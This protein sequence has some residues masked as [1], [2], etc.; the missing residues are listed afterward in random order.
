M[1]GVIGNTET[2]L[3][4]IRKVNLLWAREPGFEVKAPE[5]KTEGAAGWDLHI[6]VFNQAFLDAFLP[7][8]RR[9]IDLEAACALRSA[10]MADEESPAFAPACAYIESNAVD[11]GRLVIPP[12]ARAI[13]PSGLR[14]AIP[15]HW[16][17]EGANRGSVA[18]IQGIVHGAHVIDCDFRGMV[19][20][21]VINTSNTPKVLAGGSSLLQV[22]VR[23]VPV[24]TMTETE[25]SSLYLHAKTSARGEGSLG[26]TDKKA[27]Q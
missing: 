4:A 25:F 13:I 21:S 6:P 9:I 5:R 11:E 19:F 15:D 23:E 10:V 18:S 16:M 3:C 20:L 1:L 14:F 27:G 17:L 26:S 7:L 8:N 22:L 2:S 24:V 12:G